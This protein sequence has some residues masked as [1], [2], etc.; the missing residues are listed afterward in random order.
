VITSA[1]IYKIALGMLFP[2]FLIAV[3]VLA[4]AVRHNLWTF[5]TSTEDIQAWIA[6]YGAV[7]P[8]IYI[9][10][11]V[12][13]VVIFIVPG[14]IT[15]FVAGYL[16]GI[17]PG[18]VY[19]LIGITIGSAID[20]GLARLLG[21]AFVEGVFGAERVAR[22]DTFTENKRPQTA[23]FLL[24][25]I[26]GIPKD[27]LIYVAG[28]SRLRFWMF[29]FVSMAGRLPGIVGSALIGSSAA[30]QQWVLG[31]VVFG[32]SSVLFVLG[33]VFRDRLHQ[34]L[35]SITNRKHARND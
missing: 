12:F 4:V 8:L 21:R 1:R 6:G 25:V 30:E 11:Q 18:T 10:V 35:E 28:I 2:A 17:F 29:L 9:G 24:F 23:F 7:A 34:L 32:V 33:V 3:I 5:F 13:Q 19:S 20:F 15:Q 16:F 26:P 27:I 31:G 22:F 14:E